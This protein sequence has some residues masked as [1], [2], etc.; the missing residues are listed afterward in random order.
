MAGCRTLKLL[1]LLSSLL[2]LL[3]GLLHLLLLLQLMLLPA[4][5][6]LLLHVAKGLRF[7]LIPWVDVAVVVVVTL[8]LPAPC[9]LGWW[10]IA[11]AIARP[12]VVDKGALLIDVAR[13]GWAVSLQASDG[14]G[15]GGELV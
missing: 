3:L 14:L 12:P 8:L 2:L 9:R 7:F 13:H 10:D 5:L 6:L 1:L 11:C 4:L 15:E